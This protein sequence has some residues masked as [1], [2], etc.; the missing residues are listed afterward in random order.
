MVT[1]K[2]TAT[3]NGVQ[4]EI[5]ITDVEGTNSCIGYHRNYKFV[6]K[7]LPG[8]WRYSIYRPGESV[9][10]RSTKYK[11]GDVF[12]V[13]MTIIEADY[14]SRGSVAKRIRKRG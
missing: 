5:E 14:V 3:V 11:V 10:F 1:M 2:H 8:H 12:A 4:K 7:A 9:A 13:A 6:V